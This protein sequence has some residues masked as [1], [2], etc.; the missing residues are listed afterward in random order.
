MAEELVKEGGFWVQGEGADLA[1]GY[2]LYSRDGWGECSCVGEEDGQKVEGTFKLGCGG[3]GSEEGIPR[4]EQ[5]YRWRQSRGEWWIIKSDNRETK[6][7]KASRKVYL[8]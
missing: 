3:E 4:S 1:V 6:V 5:G 7:S 2:R 8:K